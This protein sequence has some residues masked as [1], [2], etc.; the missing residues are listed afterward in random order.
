MHFLGLST[1]TRVF[2]A[3]FE[4]EKDENTMLLE[5][6][7]LGWVW[8]AIRCLEAQR[9]VRGSVILGGVNGRRTT[10]KELVGSL[11]VL[12]PMILNDV[13]MKY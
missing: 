11:K 10:S 3:G 2:R 8:G 1:P 9:L 7:E 12:V 4:N 13:D 5:V 6:R